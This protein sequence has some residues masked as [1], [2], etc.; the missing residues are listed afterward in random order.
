MPWIKTTG[1]N[2]SALPDAHAVPNHE[3]GINFLQKKLKG[4][5]L[6]IN[7]SKVM[8]KRLRKEINGLGRTPHKN[9]WGCWERVVS[10][11][12]SGLTLPFY[13]AE[14]SYGGSQPKL[15]PLQQ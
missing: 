12:M 1:K 14:A 10:Y 11:P 6:S 2:D 3:D 9:T 7:G 8:A 13:R 5:T 15:P 4:F